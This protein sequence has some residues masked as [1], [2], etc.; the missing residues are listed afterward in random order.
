MPGQNYADSVKNVLKMRKKS[1]TYDQ[2]RGYIKRK[3]LLDELKDLYDYI[4]EITP[5]IYKKKVGQLTE[6]LKN[7][8]EAEKLIAA[9]CR[10]EKF[11]LP[12]R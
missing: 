2:Y 10:V 4:G 6:I 5:E 9:F 7:R 8:K 3:E 1:R 12:Y 11:H